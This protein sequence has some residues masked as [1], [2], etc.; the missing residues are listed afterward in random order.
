[1]TVLGHTIPW[2]THVGAERTPDAKSWYAQMK[3]WWAACKAARHEAKRA[4]L[5]AHWDA[6]REGVQIAS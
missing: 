4:A 2:G 5:K 1:M 6:R 3:M